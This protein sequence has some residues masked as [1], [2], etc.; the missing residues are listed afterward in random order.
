[1]SAAAVTNDPYVEITASQPA[2]ELVESAWLILRHLG[3]VENVRL[4]AGANGGSFTISS[5]EANPQ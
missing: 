5:R 4:E 3:E 2:G 1:M